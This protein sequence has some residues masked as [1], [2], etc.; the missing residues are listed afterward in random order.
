MV[1]C[2][3]LEREPPLLP[4][5]VVVGYCR[6]CW[7][8]RSAGGHGLS[9]GAPCWQC[10]DLHYF[11]VKESDGLVLLLVLLRPCLPHTVGADAHRLEAIP[12]QLC[13]GLAPKR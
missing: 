13:N 3:I 2:L 5:E 4:G 8:T 12:G 7:C 9:H 6:A 11:A 1:A 10:E